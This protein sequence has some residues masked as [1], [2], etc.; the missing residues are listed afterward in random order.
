MIQSLVLYSFIR[1]FERFNLHFY[2]WILFWF[3]TT[4][5]QFVCRIFAFHSK[6]KE[7]NNM[8]L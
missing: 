6:K 4:S 3:Q 7:K 5:A 8:K 2:L 1:L